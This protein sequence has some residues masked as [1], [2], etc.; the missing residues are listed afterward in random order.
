M[1]HEPIREKPT[2]RMVAGV[3][4][5]TGVAAVVVGLVSGSREIPPLSV[6]FVAVVFLYAAFTGKSLLQKRPPTEAELRLALTATASERVTALV[7]SGAIIPAVRAYRQETGAGL[8]EAREMIGRV[9]IQQLYL[10]DYPPANAP[11]LQAIQHGRTLQAIR[12]YH[13]Q[14]GLGLVEGKRAIEH[15]QLRLQIPRQE[16]A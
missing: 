12:L 6:A 7:R 16:P 14:T 10:A 4:G 13:Q 5:I 15:F 2:T 8:G 9:L 11:V 1:L 3:F